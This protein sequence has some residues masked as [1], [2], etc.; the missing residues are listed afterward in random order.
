MQSRM[1]SR[2]R[3][4]ARMQ[5]TIGA[6]Q[7]IIDNS[8]RSVRAVR[9]KKEDCAMSETGYKGS[10]HLYCARGDAGNDSL[11]GEAGEDR[12]YGGIG[13]DTLNGGSGSDRLFGE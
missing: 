3:R 9:D 12:L 10:R 1:H 13:D 6:V 7:H 5:A 11:L 2:V 8:D 4:Q